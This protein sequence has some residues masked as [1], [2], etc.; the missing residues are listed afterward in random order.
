MN[1]SLLSLNKKI[2]SSE[3]KFLLYFTTEIKDTIRIEKGNLL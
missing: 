1:K 3:I 2:I